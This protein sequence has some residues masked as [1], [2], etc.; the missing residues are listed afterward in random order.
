MNVNVGMATEMGRRMMFP[1]I[2][3]THAH[4]FR[5]AIVL[6]FAEECIRSALPISRLAG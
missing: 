2:H 6:P 4:G 3:L 5:R 1:E